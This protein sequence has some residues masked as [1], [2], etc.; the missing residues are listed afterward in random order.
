MMN[1]SVRRIELLLALRISRNCGKAG[2]DWP[3]FFRR[4]T[5]VAGKIE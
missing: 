4:E 3:L 1:C 2:L 5:A